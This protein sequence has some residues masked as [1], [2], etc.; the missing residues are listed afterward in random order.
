MATF[1][2]ILH[3][4]LAFIASLNENRWILSFYMQFFPTLSLSFFVRD[5]ASK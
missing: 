1:L 2:H 4:F 3:L 5:K